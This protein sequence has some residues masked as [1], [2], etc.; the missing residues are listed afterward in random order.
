[1]MNK[2]YRHNIY[3]LKVLSPNVCSVNLSLI[4]IEFLE[5]LFY[6]GMLR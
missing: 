4:S 2:N 5:S 6:V 3:T 1:M